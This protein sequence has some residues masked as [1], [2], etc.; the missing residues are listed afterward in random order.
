MYYFS[1]VTCASNSLEFIGKV[2]VDTLDF[3]IKDSCLC[4]FEVAAEKIRIRS[5]KSPPSDTCDTEV[6]VEIG[7]TYKNT[8]CND[9]DHTVDIL[10]YG[11]GDLLVTPKSPNNNAGHCIEL[12]AIGG[13]Q[14]I[15]VE[16][17]RADNKSNMFLSNSTFNLDV[18]DTT[19]KTPPSS[20]QQEILNMHNETNSTLVFDE[21]IPFKS[22][23]DNVIS[24][25]AANS[26]PPPET[27]TD[28]L[29]L[30]N[31]TSDPIDMIIKSSLDSRSNFTT[32]DTTPTPKPSTE[33]I[34]NLNI[35]SELL[36]TA[37]STADP[38]DI[39]NSGIFQ[40]NKNKGHLSFNQTDQADGLSASAIGFNPNKG[41]LSFNDSTTTPATETDTPS[42]VANKQTTV[43]TNEPPASVVNA[44]LDLATTNG[45]TIVFESKAPQSVTEV[46]PTTKEITSPINTSSIS[47][48]EVSTIASAQPPVDIKEEILKTVNDSVSELVFPSKLDTFTDQPLDNISTTLS[49]RFP[50]TNTNNVLNQTSTLGNPQITTPSDMPA[51]DI[52][53]DMLKTANAS[54]EPILF[55]D[56]NKTI[57]TF[58]TTSPFS[59]GS[60][61]GV[62][63]KVPQENPP[64][65]I[66]DALLENVNK[67]T[68]IIF[69][70]GTQTET[71]PTYVFPN[72]DNETMTGL[73][74][75]FNENMTTETPD[76][77][78]QQ[79]SAIIQDELLSAVN[80]SMG[81]VVMIKNESEPIILEKISDSSKPPQDVIDSILG[82][83]N[84]TNPI[85]FIRQEN[86]TDINKTSDIHL[87]ISTPSIDIS[88]SDVPLKESTTSLPLES[89]SGSS[90]VTVESGTSS[91]GDV[92]TDESSNVTTS[93]LTLST[94]SNTRTT[95]TT[96]STNIV[97]S[98]ISAVTTTGENDGTTTSPHGHTE[99]TSVSQD[100]SE[101][102]TQFHDQT[103]V[104]KHGQDE[105][106]G[107]D[108][109]TSDPHGHDQTTSDP[110]GHDQ[111]TTDPHGH[112]GTTIGEKRHASTTID[113][114]EQ[115][116]DETT[117]D[118][119]FHDETTVDPHGHGHDPHGHELPPIIVKELTTKPPRE[120]DATQQP[121]VIVE[122]TTVNLHAH[123]HDHVH[124][125]PRL[126]KGVHGTDHHN[127]GQ[128]LGTDTL[129]GKC[130]QKKRSNICFDFTFN[131]RW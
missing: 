67:S 63:L 45:S 3:P 61:I 23:I 74:M 70:D 119:P 97:I 62:T 51:P 79:P 54:E 81:D 102:S 12:E 38:I 16:C 111:T 15:I 43:L 19:D 110:H 56:S 66:V 11:G 60:T 117:T 77:S 87:E 1:V 28:I 24:E 17:Y 52:L 58:E 42:A 6:M 55:L 80:M 118:V 57:E 71:T 76:K 69:E 130:A 116:H 104:A 29:T 105:T 7:R 68:P 115:G 84:E 36:S 131:I 96:A 35:Q 124:T 13:S 108:R 88:T 4:Q 94:D 37:N 99:T 75:P 30:A 22:T 8:T 98:T 109:T 129:V 31:T 127:L 126:E 59:I 95:T 32:Q 44:L 91:I 82:D 121:A 123:D 73:P 78:P 14:Q 10:G 86:V 27:K 18:N 114:H 112:D 40:F 46:T 125:R 48:I 107:H 26:V 41:H 92:T 33:R 120:T 9:I 47:L 83:I 34:P 85:I 21:D 39:T 90:G 103:T 89:T 100:Y 64:S 122:E 101:S 20:V 49:P 65:T 50:P 25:A 128:I 113:R 93:V 53:L 106:H 2:L 72:L 5:I